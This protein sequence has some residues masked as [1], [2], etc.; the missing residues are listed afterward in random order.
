MKVSDYIVSFLEKKGVKHAYGYQGTMIAHLV[1]SIGKSSI[2][3]HSVYNEQAAAFAAVGAAKTTGKCTFAYA[4]SGPGAINLVSGIADAYY[5]SAPVLF[6]TG[7]VNTTEYTDVVELRQQAFQETKVVSI[8]KDICKYASFIKC[9]ED[10]VAELNKAWDIANEGRKG[11]VV[12]DIPMNIQRADISVTD[13]KTERTQEEVPEEV[14]ALL[15]KE[16]NNSRRPVFIFGNGVGKD[17]DSRK[18]VKKL[19]EQYNVPVITTLLGKDLIDTDDEKNMGVLGA[20]YGHRSANM[21]AYEK[22]DLIVSFGASLCRRQTGGN[23]KEFAKN[24]KIIRVDIDTNELARTI[25]DE[26]H[27]SYDVNKV[28]EALLAVN[29]DYNRE[30][31][32][33]KCRY[34]KAKFTEFDNACEGREPNKIVEEVTSNLENNI[35]VT[36]VGQHMMWVMQSAQVKNSRLLFSGGHGAMG[37]ALPAAI[38]AYLETGK[39]TMCIA[40]DGAFQMNI[41][42]LQWVFREK[43]PLCIV[44][45]N[46]SSLGLIRQQ[47]EDFFNSYY[48]GSTSIGGYTSPDFAKIAQAYNIVAFKV[49]SLIELKEI[50]SKADVDEPLLI[51]YM[52]PPTTVAIPKTYFGE[53][54][55]NQRPYI[56]DDILDCIKEI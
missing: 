3:N 49:T 22:A 2:E 5:D 41:Q 32:L 8:A 52:L 34:I 24:A 20:A 56:N 45:F 44:V 48:V 1:E 30:E 54:M 35:V 37:F 33:E 17:D 15:L 55:V 7:Q 16:L 23:T 42:E 27:V 40:G 47:Q 21:V 36:D 50:I 46:N 53:T 4:T 39:R 12:L 13:I 9:P 26:I 14:V 25:H 11:P 6:I 28:I 18:K 19:T 31:W 29:K 38:G 10:V 43:I 51:E